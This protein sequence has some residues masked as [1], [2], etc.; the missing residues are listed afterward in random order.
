MSVA[1]RVLGALRARQVAEEGVALDSY[2]K[3][4]QAIATD[5][6]VKPDQVEAMLRRSGRPLGVLE[7]DV[8][9]LV[10]HLR[11]LA[12]ARA[13]PK[14]ELDELRARGAEAAAV[15]AAGVAAI[16]AEKARMDRV[17]VEGGS[18]AVQREAE[19]VLLPL[20]D[21]RLAAAWRERLS[22]LRSAAGAVHKAESLRSG[23][24]PSAAVPTLT[25]SVPSAD[26]LAELKR[27]AAAAQAKAEQAWSE[28]LAAAA[29]LP[30]SAV[31]AGQVTS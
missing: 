9:A 21:Q 23:W 27:R 12:E 15:A 10:E 3:I 6:E 1:S 11:R 19:R 29:A 4:A 17:A 7:R 14:L 16:R 18:M 31:V 25:A 22:E 28:V 24:D 5:Q 30:L 8:G 26:E 13:V 2:E 20:V